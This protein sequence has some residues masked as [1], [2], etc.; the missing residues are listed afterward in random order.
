MYSNYTKREKI[1]T[2]TLFK[3]EILKQKFYLFGLKK[4]KMKRRIMS[5]VKK[6]II[7]K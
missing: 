4:L 2:N 5:Q 6:K 7:R 1:N 3:Y